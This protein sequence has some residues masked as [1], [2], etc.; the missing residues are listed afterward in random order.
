MNEEDKPFFL[1]DMPVRHIKPEGCP[2][3]SDWYDYGEEAL[4]DFTKEIYIAYQLVGEE[5]EKQLSGAK[6]KALTM[7]VVHMA[8]GLMFVDAYN[9]ERNKE[10]GISFE[11][12]KIETIKKLKERVENAK[13]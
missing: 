7:C 13:R 12:F 8:S 4:R 11:Q 6:A 10:D 5:L 3:I 2:G 1:S 9:Y